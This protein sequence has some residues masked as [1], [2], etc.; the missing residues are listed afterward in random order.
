MSKYYSNQSVI[1]HAAALVMLQ[2]AIKKADEIGQPQCIVIVDAS[3]EVLA[4]L[5]MTGSKFL[6]R[7]SAR[8]KALTAASIKAPSGSLPESVRT[9]VSLATDGSMT[10]L[11]GGLPIRKNGECLGGVGVGS[12]T[13]DQ[14]VE[15][16]M[17]ALQAI[18]ADM[19]F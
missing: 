4:E 17:A 11:M 16:A 10:G 18:E 14:D 15:V 5:R 19:E 2:A 1:T 9:P 3:G 8:S 13:G 12:G 6:S 7:K